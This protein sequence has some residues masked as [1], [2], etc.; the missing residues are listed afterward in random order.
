MH[1]HDVKLAYASALEFFYYY[2]LSS[3]LPVKRDLC[4]QQTPF[5]M[6]KSV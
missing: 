4:T 3:L 5:D 1:D 2:L 6:V